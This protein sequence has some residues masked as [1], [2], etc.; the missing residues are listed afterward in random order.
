MDLSASIEGGIHWHMPARLEV[1]FGFKLFAPAR[2][3]FAITLSNGAAQM[4]DVIKGD[5]GPPVFNG[6]LEMKRTT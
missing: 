5:K 6:K 2:G 1:V 3:I 4:G